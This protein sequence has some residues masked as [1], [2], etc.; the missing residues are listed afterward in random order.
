MSTAHHLIDHFIS[1]LHGQKDSDWT[2]SME[3]FVSDPSL[4]EFTVR[5]IGVSLKAGEHIIY[6]FNVA[7]PMNATKKLLKALGKISDEI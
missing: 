4:P 1:E 2:R 5:A 6:F 3:Y 7:R